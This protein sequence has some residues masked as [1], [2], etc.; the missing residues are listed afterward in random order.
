MARSIEIAAPLLYQRQFRNLP[1]HLLLVTLGF[2]V[3]YP[4]FL[5]VLNSFQISPPGEP[6]RFSLD[7]WQRALSDPGTVEALWNSATLTGVRQLISLPLGILL[8]WFL[9]RTD[10]PG[11][12][13][14]QFLFWTSYFVPSLAVTQGMIMLF[15]PTFGLV[16][17]L[18]KGLPFV[19]NNLFDIYSWWGIVW[20]HLIA[21]TIALKVILLVPAFQNMDASLEEASRVCGVSSAGTLLR[22]VI[23]ALAPAIFV[24]LLLS[25]IRGLEAFEIEMVLGTPGRI[26]VYSTK[27]Y[28]LLHLEPPLFGAA[29][30]LSMIVVLLMLP[31]IIFQRWITTRRRYTTVTGRYRFGLTR[32]GKWR[33]PAFACVFG[34][35]C[36]V[37][38]MPVIFLIAGTFMKLYGFFDMPEPWTLRHWQT[39][40]SDPIFLQ[41]LTNTLVLASGSALLA[42]VVCSSIAYVIART[43]Y[44]GNGALDVV[45][46]VPHSLPGIIFGLTLLWLFLGTDFLRPLYGTV[47]IMIVANVLGGMTLGIQ[48]VK[49]NFV[50]LAGELEE[51]SW[52]AGGTRWYTIRRV[53]LPI[54]APVLLSVGLLNFVAAARSV[55]NVALLAVSTTRPLSLL[56]LDYMVEGQYE[57]ASIIG[58]IIAFICVGVLF[59]ARFFGLR[60]GFR[61]EA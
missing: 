55:S 20:T 49:S 13:W 40:L 6:A 21:T 37:S 12:D 8:A 19:E 54:F 42:V 58:T 27:I 7:G 24:A 44:W 10:L 14:L 32:L 4:L 50:Q 43:R 48:I 1:Y 41:S 36:V 5:L 2:F 61:R 16:N 51:A 57:A 38:V 45:S 15:D 39:V 35:A 28:R 46:W 29:T 22:I 59:L 11:K 52:I 47:L 56:Q 26:D 17:Q 30:A 9:A 31:L 60:L 34:V 53:L 33:W 18:I 25:I 23:P 3:I